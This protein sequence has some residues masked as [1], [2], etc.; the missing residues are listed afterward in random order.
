MV[1]EVYVHGQLIRAPVQHQLANNS[2]EFVQFVFSLSDDWD[3]LT[4]FAQFRQGGNTYNIYLDSDS[5]CYLPPEIGSGRVS[6]MLYGT[7]DTVIGTTNAITMRVADNKYVS[8]AQSTEIT[9]SLYQQLVNEV[10]AAIPTGGNVGQVLTR[11]A[12]GKTAWSNAGLPTDAQVTGAVET[13]LEENVD[14]GAGAVLDKTLTIDGAAA[15]A[16]AT[17]DTVND[18]NSA[19]NDYL[20]GVNKTFSKTGSGWDYFLCPLYKGVKYTVQNNLDSIMAIRIYRAD[21]SRLDVGSAPANGTLS[22]V[23]PT[24]DEFVRIGGYFAK[25]GSFTVTNEFSG[26][27]TLQNAAMISRGL[28]LLDGFTELKASD[29]ELGTISNGNPATSTQRARSINFIDVYDKIKIYIPDNSNFDILFEC[30]KADGTWTSSSN[31]ITASTEVELANTRYVKILLKTKT[32]IP[33]TIS[34]SMLSSAYFAIKS[35]S[36]SKNLKLTIMSH[37]CGHWNYGRS[38]EYSGDDANDKVLEWKAMLSRAKPDVVLAQEFSQN[39]TADSS[40]SAINEIYKPLFPNTYF[41]AYGRVLSKFKLL[42]YWNINLNVEYDGT[43]YSRSAGASIAN[44]DGV[45]ILFVS[46]HFHPGYGETDETVREMERDALLDAVVNYDRVIIGGDFNSSA[47][48]FYTPF[49]N[50]GYACANHGYWGTI[51]TLPADGVNSLVPESVDNIIIKGFTFYDVY[52][53]SSDK[54]TSD[55]YP[56]V[57]DVCLT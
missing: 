16:K 48:S 6:L 7:G 36:E 54:C 27:S 46:V 29:F 31:W 14:T 45:D 44:I 15:D 43:T 1:L 40:I 10:K 55:H 33:A 28:S 17:G 51:D 32:G 57:A 3:G 21:D 13:W 9:A 23:V 39:F 34:D 4:T 53:N 38:T 20:Y 12:N 50:A 41:Y 25:T 52:S 18:L 11:A 8:D 26:V 56:I 42:S 22:F 47:D 24:T 19:L 2:Q 37:N 35:N 49:V 5:S 30:Y